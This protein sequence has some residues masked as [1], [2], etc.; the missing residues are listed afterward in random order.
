[1]FTFTPIAITLFITTL[2]NL[3]VTDISWQRRKNKEG[4]Y[5]SLGMMSI[6]V[7]TLA[8][9]LGYAAIPVNLKILFAK[10]DAIGYNSALSM[11][12][13][14]SIYYAGLGKWVENKWIRTILYLVPIS[15][16]LLIVTNELHKWVWVGFVPIGNNIVVF[17]HGTGF[18]WVA[19]TGYLMIF[20][21]IS[22]LWL[23]AI[24]GSEISRRQGRV[25]LFASIFPIGSNLVYLFGVK[26]FEG[27]DWSSITFS[28]TGALFLYALY[29]TRLLDLAPI[30]RDKL[31]NSLSDGMIVLDMQ[32]RIIDINQAA[33]NMMASQS[34]KLLG[35]DLTEVVPATHTWLAQP[36]QGNEVKDELEV[37]FGT[38][39]YF[40]FLISPLLEGSKKI[41]GQL[42]IFRD[43]TERK[44]N[45]IRL[46]QLTKELQETQAQVIDQQRTFAKQEERK[47]LGRDMHDS[48][49]QSIH[50]LTL[51]SETLISLLE[52]N[53]TENAIAV[54]KRIQESGQQALRQIRLLLYETQP[55][56]TDERVNLI[57]A[58][59]DRLDMVERRA[60]I[61]AEIIQKDVL[62]TDWPD[63]WNEN[64]YWIIVE[65]LNNSI[66]H[67]QSKN[68]KI[69]FVHIEHQLD[70]TVKDDGIGF[71]PSQVPSGGFGMRIMRERATLL[72]GELNIISYLGQGTSINFRT[73]IGE[74]HGSY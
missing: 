54:A 12:L 22:I 69:F 60:G 6:T 73:K 30:A 40:D 45:E 42:I 29:N 20:S 18:L 63:D 36:Y 21:M 2:I 19:V 72:G 48:V 62:V 16:I 56:L 65:A 9:A 11:L 10:I 3:I 7:W 71:D 32:N 26:G 15:N 38:K 46:L 31:V 5:F 27:V 34:S 51:F 49:N 33:A 43:V 59:E 24:K 66:K 67:A 68:V 37:D 55:V 58:L 44:N 1:M 13:F 8:V 4:I 74:Q 23:T 70:I 14:F 57:S 35:R 41:V 25:L 50:S 61:T 39:R 17:K 47:R 64:L 52:K 28:I 53:Q